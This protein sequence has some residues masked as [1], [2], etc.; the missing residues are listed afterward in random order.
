MKF[1]LVIA[2]FAG[3]RADAEADADPYYLTYGHY[4]YGLAA[5]HAVP[6]VPVV[7]SVDVKPAEV[8]TTTPVITYGYP[9]LHAPYY[10]LWGHGLPLTGAPA[11]AAE[12]EAPAVEAAERRKREADAEAEAEADPYYLGL[13]RPYVYTPLVKPVVKKVEV[14]APALTYTYGYPYHYGYPYSFGYPYVVTKPVEAE[15]EAEAV[16]AERKKREA[17]AD[18]EADPYYLT[19]PYVYTAPVV[20]PAVKTVEVKTP[21]VTYAYHHAL[22]YIHGYHGLYPY[23]YGYHGYPLVVTKPVEAEA[24][25][26]EAERKKRDADAEADPAILASSTRV[27]TPVSPVTYAHLPYTLPYATRGVYS[28]F[29]YPYPHY[30]HWVGK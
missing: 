1:L 7:K 27:L 5:H 28:N 26:V 9:Y 15:A 29:G 19:Y 10:G 24:E 16:E 21:A 3:V 20:K 14:K 30:A 4:P 13:H 11:A 2:L 6:Y 17:E 18:P 12:A 25:A 8:K 22:P 23:S